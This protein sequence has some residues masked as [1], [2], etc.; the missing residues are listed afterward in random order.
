MREVK[1]K[2]LAKNGDRVLIIIPAPIMPE[3]GSTQIEP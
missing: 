2:V 3:S 1:G